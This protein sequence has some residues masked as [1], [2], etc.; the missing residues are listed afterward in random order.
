MKNIKLI[1]LDLDG[2][3]L[4]RNRITPRTRHAL[5][6]AIRKGVH[7]V[8][9][10]G[11]VYNALPSSIFDIEGLEY[12]I[13]SNGAV[14]TDLRQ[15][16]TVY[17]NCIDKEALGSVLKLLRE[18]SC[19]PVEVFTGG[20]AYID[21]E[22]YESL[23]KGG[24]PY[25]SRNYILRTRKPVERI[26]NFLEQ[27]ISRIE[28]INIMF[29]HERDRKMIRGLLEG[30]EGITLTSSTS[31]NLEIGGAFTSKASGIMAL[32]TILGIEM[33]QVMACGD[34]YN[35]MAMLQAAET[36][37][38]MSGGEK[39]V[40]A[41]ADLTAPSNEEEGVAYMVEK[42]VLGME[43]PVWMLIFLRLKNRSLYLAWRLIRKLS[44][45]RKKG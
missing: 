33:E 31:S 44:R 3:T 26:L 23:G 34:S 7:V 37:I 15:Q 32:C 18:Q 10:T 5:E 45:M 22:V 27:N 2:T 20:Q 4:T 28:N 12:V 19:F 14:I 29:E 1:A 30:M 39:E 17:E 38:A 11:R 13:T 35:D 9:A 21:R 36:G 6:E 42:L 16:K 41:A 40:I 43:R 24:Y 25:L 8:I